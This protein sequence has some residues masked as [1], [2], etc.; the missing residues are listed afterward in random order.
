MTAMTAERA[1]EICREETFRA[2]DR[3]DT[4]LVDCHYSLG[5]DALELS[6]DEL[7]VHVREWMRAA[8]EAP[9]VSV[10]PDVLLGRPA[11]TLDEFLRGGT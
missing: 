10:A 4:Q 6:E 11:K 2:W 9:A 8:D 1:Q 5:P 3:P 7:R